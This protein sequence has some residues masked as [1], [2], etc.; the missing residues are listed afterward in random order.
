M[1]ESAVAIE[2]GRDVLRSGI[3]IASNLYSLHV[4]KIGFMPDADK[5][6]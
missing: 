4:L 5:V 3:K 2:K 6:R 1:P